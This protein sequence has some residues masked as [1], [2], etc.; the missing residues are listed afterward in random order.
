MSK[1]KAI[2]LLDKLKIIDEVKTGKLKKDIA[3]K[4]GLAPSTLS[5][6]LKNKKKFSNLRQIPKM[7]IAKN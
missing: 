1:R 4:Y 7:S 5:T 3:E 6:I 2:G